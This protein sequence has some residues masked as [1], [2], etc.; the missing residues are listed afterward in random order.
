MSILIGIDGSEAQDKRRVGVSEYAYNLIYALY[1]VSIISKSKYRFIIYLKSDKKDDLPPENSNF[2]YKVL[3]GNRFWVFRNLLPNLNKDKNID[4]FFSPTHYLP[5]F[6]RTPQVCTI[7]DLGY[8][9][10]SEQFKRYDFWQLK[11]WTAISLY[12]SKYIISV[13]ESTKN[14]IVRHYPKC[15]NKIKVVYHGIDHKIF[16][17]NISS[18]VVRQVKNKYKIHKNYILSVGTL[19]PSKNIKGMMRAFHKFIKNE[20]RLSIDYQMVISGKKGW[21]YNDI[22]NF[23]KENNLE[24]KII[25]TDYV[26]LKEKL[27]LYKGARFLLSPSYWEGFGMHVLESMACKTPVVLS[28]KGSLYEV[29]GS[30]GIYVNPYSEDSIEKAI[31]KLVKMDES[32]YNKLS[33]ACLKRSMSF[34][35][36]KTAQETLKVLEKLSKVK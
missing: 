35:W 8:L 29:A 19:K 7:H 21:M 22:F 28:S 6:T 27:A 30:A 26:S 15:L 2:T 32:E 12:I 36:D 3:P 1:R 9:M 18:I 23:V 25:F 20:P 5:V 34:N 14:D 16:N 17:Q 11:Y 13:S 33:N 31:S 10:F 24:D 4:V